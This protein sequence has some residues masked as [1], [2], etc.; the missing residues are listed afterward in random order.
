MTIQFNKITVIKGRGMDSVMLHT[1]LPEATYPYKDE[2]IIYFDVASGCGVE[3]C[4]ANFG[5][6]IELVEKVI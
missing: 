1:L 6:E 5:P 4:R 2:L 3:Y